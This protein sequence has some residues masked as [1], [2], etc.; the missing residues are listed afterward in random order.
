MLITE[1]Y[2]KA[3]LEK[4]KSF[5]TGTVSI[6]NNNAK[7]LAS[8]NESREGELSTTAGYILN[9]KR[10]SIIDNSELMGR[11]ENE[12]DQ[13][14]TYGV[15]LFL[16]NKL[17]G[18]II[19]KDA[20]KKVTSIGAI[21]KAA[22][23]SA[24]EFELFNHSIVNSQNQQI[25]L[26]YSLLEDRPDVNSI[27]SSMNKLEI[28]PYLYRTVIVIELEYIQN[29]YFNINLNLGYQPSIEKS[30]QQLLNLVRSNPY[31]NSQDL[32]TIYEEKNIVIIK[33][34]NPSSDISK[35]YLAI[36]KIC[37]SIADSL[38]TLNTYKFRIAY[39][40]LYSSV[41]DIHKSYHEAQN[42][43]NIVSKKNDSFGFFVLDDILFDN[44]CQ[45]L[46]TQLVNK[47][48]EPVLA[49][50]TKKNGVVQTELLDCAD[51]LV[52]NSMNISHASQQ[53]Y[54]HRNT[55][56]ARMKKLKA[57]TGLDPYTS[58]KDAFMVKMLATYVRMNQASGSASSVENINDKE[59]AADGTDN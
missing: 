27:I 48:I 49:K 42:I 17:W 58:F 25:S 26:V 38:S 8:T 37:K 47:I 7:I 2:L 30:N 39:G 46:P 51:L 52:E 53:G 14:V 12:Q 28:V 55:I 16:E 23:E 18:T 3:L 59:E 31:L 19:I 10:S 11:F 20:Y 43:I 34:F 32:Y 6:T 50:L 9:L 21:L 57:L 54:L 35:V 5:I 4:Y 36:D 22:V 13:I 41:E 40:N 44:V 15:P 1:K 33:S 24:L 29:K 56:T 45:S